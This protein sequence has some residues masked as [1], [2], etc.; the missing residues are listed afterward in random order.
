VLPAAFHSFHE[1]ERLGIFSLEV[2]SSIHRSI[3]GPSFS[4]VAIIS[5][6]DQSDSLEKRISSSAISILS[7]PV[8]GSERAT[9]YDSIAIDS[10]D[11]NI[12]AALAD[13]IV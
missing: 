1:S 5:E 13:S 7:S 2:L 12:R 11:A 6:Y 8:D 3:T 4:S 9:D 10:T